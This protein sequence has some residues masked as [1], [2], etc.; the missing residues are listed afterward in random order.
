MGGVE[1]A[2]PAWLAAVHHA[3]AAE[4]ADPRWA[5]L[6]FSFAERLVNVPIDLSG[7]G[8]DVGFTCTLHEG[9]LD[10]VATPSDEVEFAQRVDY[11]A[12]RQLASQAYEG[13]ASGGAGLKEHFAAEGRIVTTGS[14]S[15]AAGEFWL[16]VHNRLAPLTVV[17]HTINNSPAPA[18][19]V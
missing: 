4:A 2:T 11:G 17:T 15:E 14:R 9:K 12:A 3:V 16:A 8:A 13:E 5:A 18:G 1:L 7:D 6:E 19:E 10:F